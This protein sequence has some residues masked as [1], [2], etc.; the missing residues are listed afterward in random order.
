MGLDPEAARAALQHFYADL[1]K[2]IN[3]LLQLS[4]VVPSEW[5]REVASSSGSSSATSSSSGI[6]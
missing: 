6:K 4:G 3:E 5:L 2:A 1:P